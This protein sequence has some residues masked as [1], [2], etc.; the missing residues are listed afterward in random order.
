L[1]RSLSQYRHLIARTN[2][3]LLDRINQGDIRIT[4]DGEERRTPLK[5]STLVQINANAESRARAGAMGADTVH[6][7]MTLQEL[8]AEF[9]SVAKAYRTEV[10][11]GHSERTDSPTTT[12]QL[13]HKG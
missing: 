6:I 2:E 8:A 13:E 12:P 11:D 5:A 7:T 1:E 4:R 10:I 9:R 3:E